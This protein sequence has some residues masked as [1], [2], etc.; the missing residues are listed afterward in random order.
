M[1]IDHAFTESLPDLIGA[2]EYNQY[3]DGTLVRIRI[4]ITENGVELLGDGIRPELVEQVVSAISDGV[5][6]PVVMEQMLCG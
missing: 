6:D 1:K 2:H 4:S 5:G 3:P